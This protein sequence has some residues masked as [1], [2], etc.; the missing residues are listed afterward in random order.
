MLL[1]HRAAGDFED[2]TVNI[3]TLQFCHQ[4]MHDVAKEGNLRILQFFFQVVLHL[5][6]SRHLSRELFSD[7]GDNVIP[8]WKEHVPIDG[9]HQ[10]I[11]SRQG[12]GGVTQ[13]VYCSVRVYPTPRIELAE[14]SNRKLVILY[15]FLDFHHC[16]ALSESIKSH[17]WSNR[18]KYEKVGEVL[19]SGYC[20]IRI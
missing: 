6:Q 9:R 4:Q 19:L 5:R 8:I 14:W 20:L 10:C 12:Q 11:V 7:G 13:V 18:E 16:V 1:L 17:K 3:E 2:T 15:H